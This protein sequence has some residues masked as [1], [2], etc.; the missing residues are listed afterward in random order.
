MARLP[1]IDYKTGGLQLGRQDVYGPVRVANAEAAALSQWA[2]AINDIETAIVTN[3]VAEASA[4]MSNELSELN[5]Y[6]SNTKTYDPQELRAAGMTIDEDENV[7]AHRVATEFYK[8]R[9]QEIY[10]DNVKDL[11]RKGR[12]V[13]EKTYASKYSTG[14]TAVVGS[15]IKYGAQYAVAQVDIGF[16]EAVKSGDADAAG[17]IANVALA[18]GTWDP[19][20]YATKMIP[21]EGRVRETQYLQTL[22]MTDDI[23]ALEGGQ[24]NAT[25]D[26]LLTAAAKNRMY[27]AYGTKIKQIE[28]EREAEIKAEKT[29]NSSLSLTQLQGFLIEGKAYTRQEMMDATANFKP[30]DRKTAMAAWGSQ[31]GKVSISDSNT[32]L[33]AAQLIRGTLL[34]NPGVDDDFYTRRSIVQERLDEMA[35]VD[36]TLTAEDH[37]IFTD[38]LKKTSKMT[39]TT[40]EFDQVEDDIYLSL[41]GGS[42][43]A[44]PILPGGE[45][46]I[47]LS[48]AI[49][50]LHDRALN[51]GE[52]F[53]PAKWWRMK[54]P[55]MITKAAEE[56]SKVWFES[57][58]RHY[59]EINGAGDYDPDKTAHKLNE[60]LLRGDIDGQIME[61]TLTE[62]DAY[63]REVQ[64]LRDEK[65]KADGEAK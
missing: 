36:G 5:A 24:H 17:D 57:V 7:P 33:E 55:L 49:G 45:K 46:Q 20:H 48:L 29:E 26:P 1:G 37:A 3:G 42:K 16:E 51:E 12:R 41:V 63:F 35:F 61:R 47:A 8:I 62:A 34:P 25:I 43:D 6:V 44:I 56:N 21:M 65:L 60:M 22:E 18:N 52:R 4:K 39:I 10:E 15:S 50:E 11:T 13:L 58:S 19:D 53:N 28:R 30:A 27:T 59:V 23:T 2:T 32:K 40:P 38:R 64:R 14:I 54:K 9:A 31:Q